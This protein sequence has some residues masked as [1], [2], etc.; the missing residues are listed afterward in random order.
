MSSTPEN[1][2]A[3]SSSSSGS[4]HTRERGPSSFGARLPTAKASRYGGTGWG[5]S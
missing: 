1:S 4:A 2:S 5:I 3:A